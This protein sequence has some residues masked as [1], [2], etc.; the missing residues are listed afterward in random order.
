MFGIDRRR[1][2]SGSG[3]TGGMLQGTGR[4]VLVVLNWDCGLRVV[5]RANGMLAD[6]VC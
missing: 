2:V 6:L 5:L 1:V 4:Q 3:Q